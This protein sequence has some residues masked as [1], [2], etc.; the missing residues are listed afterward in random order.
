MSPRPS[1][2]SSLQILHL[3]RDLLSAVQEQDSA[4]SEWHGLRMVTL[5]GNRAVGYAILENESF[6]LGR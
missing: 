2:A 6:L 1:K 5:E 4:A 3:N